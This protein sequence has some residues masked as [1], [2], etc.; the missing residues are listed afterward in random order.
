MRKGYGQFCPLAMAA[1]FFCTR[2][3][4]LIL[5]EL[6]LGSCTF[7][8]IGRGVSRMSR[9]LLSTRLKELTE[10]GV[11]A[12][13]ATAGS[14]RVEYRLTPAG[15]ALGQIVFALADWSQEWLQEAPALID[16]DTDHL[17]WSLR[18]SAR[19]LPALPEPFVTHIHF[20]DQPDNRR[21]AWLVFKG[22]AV[23]LCIV[24]HDFDVHV[25]IEASAADLTRVYMGWMDLERA[26]AER[27]VIFRGDAR[28]IALAPQW[29]GRS[30]LAG[31]NKQP[32]ALR[33]Q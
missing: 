12:R 8:D 21:N 13:Y 22:G 10:R 14:Q 29:L 9:T 31:I 33:V 24:D 3:T 23:D 25:Q 18:R 16:I 11:L 15:Q 28:C 30:R 4:V 5:R 27:R 6:M 26:V 7:N 17:L 1:E 20:S 2:W 19:P 32:P